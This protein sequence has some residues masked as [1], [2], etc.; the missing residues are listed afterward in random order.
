M[1]KCK[2]VFQLALAIVLVSI[3]LF[4]ESAFVVQTSALTPMSSVSSTPAAPISID[5]A[6][7]AASAR[8][9]QS[10]VTTTISTTGSSDVVIL[11]GSVETGTLVNVLHIKDTQGLD[12][13]ARTSSPIFYGKPSYAEFFEYYAITSTPL[14]G[15]IVNVTISQPQNFTV[16]LFGIS[17]ANTNSPFDPGL[18]EPAPARSSGGNAN[19]KVLITT[20]NPDDLIIGLAFISGG[21]IITPESSFN[22]IGKSCEFGSSPVAF[23]EYQVVSSVQDGFVS[24]TLSKSEN[25]IMVGDAIVQAATSSSTTVSC[26]STTVATG[27]PTTCVATVAGNNPT[28]SVSWQSSGSGTFSSSSC[29]L[30]SSFSCSVSYTPSSSASPVTITATYS[31]DSSNTPGQPQTFLLAVILATSSTTVSCSPSPVPTGSSSTC[32]AT[33]TGSSPTGTISFSSSDS[34]GKFGSSSTC[35]LSS[36][37]C[38]VSYTP[39]SATSPA[40]INASYSGDANNLPSSGSF[41]FSLPPPTTTSNSTTRSGSTSFFSSWTFIIAMISV[42]VIVIAGT[43]IG[44]LMRRRYY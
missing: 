30:S 22:C 17:G 7:P 40:I 11:Y 24:A 23:G 43:T 42:A 32:T 29:T 14:S 5:G 35:T 15:D 36:S 28:G 9:N 34:A 26:T 1:I 38:S 4:S 8:D 39:S 27:S 19:P 21:P 44:V 37:S 6:S 33:V 41:H 3:F 18:P 13:K 20:S 12:W 10:W 25:W 31:G 2:K 16:K